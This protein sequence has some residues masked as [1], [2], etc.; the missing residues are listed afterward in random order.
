MDQGNI[1]L[2]FGDVREKSIQTPNDFVSHMIEHIAWRMGLSITLKWDNE[3]WHELGLGLGRAIH[4][5]ACPHAGQ[6]AALGMI[7]DGSAAVAIVADHQD[8]EFSAIGQVNLNHFLTSRCEQIVSG[9]PLIGLLEGLAA[10]LPAGIRI[11]ILSFEDPHH[12]WEGIFRGVGIALSRLYA[13]Q[14]PLHK[15][16]NEIKGDLEVERDCP[17]GEIAVLEKGVNRAVVKRGTAESGVTVTID[18]SQEVT[19]KVQLEVGDSIRAAVAGLGNMLSLLAQE[20][21]AIVKVEFK[22]RQLSS[23]HVVMEDIGLVLGR[24]LLEILKIRME[25]YGVNAAGSNLRTLADFN[26]PSVKCGLSI[27]GRKF[28]RFAAAD[29]DMEN[30][31]CEFLLGQDVMGNLRSEDLDD[32]IDGLAGGLCSSI[33]LYLPEYPDADLAWQQVFKSLGVA[34]NEAFAANPYRKGVPPGVKATLF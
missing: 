6:A 22:A 15:L 25:K 26:S 2:S 13:P 9:S 18:F 21:G 1:T 7:D 19:S 29:S 11:K 3:H 24:A 34:L 5:L 17:R 23:S 10:G 12:T 33:F 16:E 14:E 4:A 32:F 28:W 30:L 20:L 27:E 31:R 8:V